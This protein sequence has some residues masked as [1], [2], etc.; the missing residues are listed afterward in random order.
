MTK[1][2]STFISSIGILERHGS[3]DP[4][5]ADLAYDS[6]KVHEGS[7]FFALPGLHADGSAFIADAIKRGAKAIIHEK[8]LESY[9]SG[10]VY[11][12]VENSRFA[13]S[14][15][16]AAFH[17]HPSRDLVV[18]GVTGTEGKSTTVSLVWQLLTLSGVK[19]GLSR[20]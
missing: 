14:P 20:R 2:L 18:I 7:L 9:Q 8:T 4:E 1:K 12:R 13:M 16:A 10:I 19:A 5:I 3:D 17:D 15:I 11:L 6:R